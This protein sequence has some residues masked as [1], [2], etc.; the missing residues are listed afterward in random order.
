[1]V[2]AEEV[3]LSRPRFANRL[4]VVILACAAPLGL[5]A[6]QTKNQP[7][8]HPDVHYVP[9]PSAVVQAMLELANVTA[10]DVVYDLGS[11]DGRI[12]ITAAKAFGARGVGI[13]LDPDLVKRAVR[14]AA[15]A[16]VA[17]KVTF[18]QGDIFKADL[19]PAT[20]VTLYLLR[21]INLRLQPKLMRELKPGS[22]VVS[23]RFD[24]GD[25]KP[26]REVAVRGTRVYLWTIR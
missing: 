11:G 18:I 19:S 1:V 13:E 23:H 24:M 20:V 22:R 8:P 26:E 21:S 7:T 6:G 25:W 16:G 10:D 15:R 12:V 17:D 4:A 3:R 2:R 9:T 5:A 14:N